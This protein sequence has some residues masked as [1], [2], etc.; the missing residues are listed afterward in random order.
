MEQYQ[1]LEIGQDG[2]RSCR[3]CYDSN[4]MEQLIAPCLCDGDL[5]YVHRECL[6]EYRAIHISS[7]AFTQCNTCR[8]G[9]SFSFSGWLLFSVLDT[10]VSDL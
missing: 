3:I 1:D 6:D 4:E 5:K 2:L 10:S 7:V 8:F 9:M